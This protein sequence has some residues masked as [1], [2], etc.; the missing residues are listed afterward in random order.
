MNRTSLLLLAAPALVLALS[1][2]PATEATVSNSEA[3]TAVDESATAS[4]AAGLAEGTIEIATDFTLG[5]ALKDAALQ[6]KSFIGAELP[7]ATVTVADATL[8]VSYGTQAVGCTWHGQ[9]ITGTHSITVQKDDM[10]A[11]LVHHEWTDLSNGRVSVSGSADVTWDATAKSRHIVH[12]LDWTRLSDGRTGKGTGDRT[13]TALGGDWKAGV[14][15]EG[16]RTWDGKSGHWSLAIEGV[17]WRWQDPV[18]EKGTYALTNPENKE[19]TLDF[20]R[21]DEDTI[22]VTLTGAK[23]D[24]EFDVSKTGEVAGTDGA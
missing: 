11:V 4:Q 18:P 1:G 2:C 22:H 3:L 13:Q 19:L 6:I 9:T 12:E 10:N 7:C 5:G 16:Q 14:S 20:E 23:R 15:I 8:T 17:D 24:F 21:V